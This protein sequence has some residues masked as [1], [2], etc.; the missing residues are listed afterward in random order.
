[1]QFVEK[2][3]NFE[4]LMM[5][6]EK[7]TFGIGIFQFAAFE[8]SKLVTGSGTQNHKVTMHNGDIPKQFTK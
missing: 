8:T 3:L 6:L 7:V 4:T 2:Y 1:M 5:S